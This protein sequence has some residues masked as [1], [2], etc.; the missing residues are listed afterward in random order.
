MPCRCQ[1]AYKQ[2]HKSQAMPQ[3][4]QQLQ[5]VRIELTSELE[6][7]RYD[8]DIQDKVETINFDAHCKLK[9]QQHMNHE[10]MAPTCMRPH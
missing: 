3:L 10:P 9:R 7:V 2:Q 6:S 5:F 8:L 1:D 4:A